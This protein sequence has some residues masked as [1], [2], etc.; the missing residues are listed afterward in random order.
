M[1]DSIYEV[2]V[3]S[4][5]PLGMKPAKKEAYI[6]A[7][8]K[9]VLEGKLLGLSAKELAL[10]SQ[11]ASLSFRSP[12]MPQWRYDLELLDKDGAFRARP[13]VSPTAWENFDPLGG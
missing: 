11:G 6:P 3:R 10:I 8:S 9:P 12:G 7:F 13:S 5:D 1:P 2:Y 4:A